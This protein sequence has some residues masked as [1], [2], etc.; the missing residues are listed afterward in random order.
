LDSNYSATRSS[1]GVDVQRT[2]VRIGE[3][4]G[5]FLSVFIILLIIIPGIIS[6][7]NVSDVID[8]APTNYGET[9]L[10]YRSTSIIVPPIDEEEIRQVLSEYE[11]L[12]TLFKRP[13]PDDFIHSFEDVS[14][15]RNTTTI[16]TPYI[17]KPVR[18]VSGSKRPGVKSK[19]RDLKST[20]TRY[21]FSDEEKYLVTDSES[22]D[23][24]I[25]F[26]EKE[27]QDKK[28]YVSTK[29]DKLSSDKRESICY[30]SRNQSKGGNDTGIDIRSTTRCSIQL[31]S[32]TD[33]HGY[34]LF[35]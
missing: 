30:I 21:I 32:I 27:K 6:W 14:D 20:S 3:V 18:F 5:G 10:F 35:C 13:R 28:V 24:V 26:T 7:N 22:L 12:S 4:V 11:R 19:K 29:S 16:V 25:T 8:K 31:S 33:S 23:S 34:K 1:T 15:F 2:V 17:R 9:S